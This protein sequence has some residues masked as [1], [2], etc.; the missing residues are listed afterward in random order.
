M[1]S[2]K[3]SEKPTPNTTEAQLLGHSPLHQPLRVSNELERTT[4]I[5][6]A[7]SLSSIDRPPSEDEIP[8]AKVYHPY[9]PHVLALLIPASI[10][11]T[12][13]RVGLLALTTYDGRAIF[14]LAWVQATGCFFMGIGLGLKEPIGQFYGPLYTAL[15]TGFCGSLTTFS[16]WQLD[17]F[18]SWLNPTHANRDWF[19]DVLDGLAK[20]V[21][22]LA[23]SLTS[24]RFGAHVASIVRPFIPWLPPP[25]RAVR[26]IITGLSVLVYA[27][28]FPAYFR[29]SPSFRHQATAAILFSFPGTLSRYLLSINLNPTVKLF[30]IGTFTANTFGTALIGAFH[31]LQS[32]RT[33]PSPN[34]C[35]VLQGM[36]DGYCGCLT[37]VST[38]ATE[39]AVLSPKKAWIYVVL[40]WVTCQLLLLVILGSSYWAGHVSENITCVFA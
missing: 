37:T 23:I 10:F 29:M 4:S 5:E 31:V 34:G 8:P 20:T 39:V 36:I 40:S 35:A 38:F 21:F 3:S 7:R 30:P 1:S 14:P 19:R 16:S 17:I 18:D 12:L 24:V 6:D 25:S 32:T 33:P 2:E 27:G 13:A 28:A 22:T 11:G 9:S 15:T 26:N